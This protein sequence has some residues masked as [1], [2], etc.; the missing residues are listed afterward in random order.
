MDALERGKRVLS[1][2]CDL[3]GLSKNVVRAHWTLCARD[4][5]R[6]KK[7]AGTC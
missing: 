5:A 2:L 1:M 4:N 3:I 6:D 7:L